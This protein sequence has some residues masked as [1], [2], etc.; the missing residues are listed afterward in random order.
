MSSKFRSN[1]ISGRVKIA[2]RKDDV[3]GSEYARLARKMPP[4]EGCGK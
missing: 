1:V 2:K 4:P 3:R